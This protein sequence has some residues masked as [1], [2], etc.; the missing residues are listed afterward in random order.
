M[1]YALDD[2]EV[3]QLR[4]L[5]FR[6]TFTNAEMLIAVCRTDPAVVARIL[7]RPLRPPTIPLVMAFVASYPETNFGVRYHEA[8]LVVH[9]A[10]GGRVG[11][12]CVAMPVDDDTAMIAGR[13]L[14]GFPKKM[15]EHIGLERDG[16]AIVGRA[17]RKGCE[18]LRIELA[19]GEPA[20]ID[21]LS[22]LSPPSEDEQGRRCLA[23][24]SYLFK[25]FPSASA[26]GFDHLPR[27]IE[28]TTLFRPRDDLRVGSGRV[29]VRSSPLDPLG[30]VPIVGEPLVVVHGHWDNTMLPGRVMAR[31]WN[32]RRFAK[33]AFFKTDMTPALLANGRITA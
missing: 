19:R 12:Y 24:T 13:E 28:Q 21:A 4:E 8:A 29:T 11:G 9:A 31:A 15:A 7:P 32:A 5:D 23:L 17:V 22:A 14:Y 1:L 16:D 6:P 33:H 18:I 10:Q 27:L 25:F 26:R 30:E 3:K 2:R 20:D